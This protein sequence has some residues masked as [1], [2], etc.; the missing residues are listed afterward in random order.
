MNLIGK[1]VQHKY[2]GQIGK[3]IGISDGF[4]VVSFWDEIHRYKQEDAFE[5][6]EL[7]NKHEQSL[8]ENQAYVA[9]V[10]GFRSEEGAAS[11]DFF[12]RLRNGAAGT[13]ERVPADPVPECGGCGI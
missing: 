3:I 7:E 13:D 9:G 6:I 1:K 12:C 5:Y 8:L 4:V 10:P 11:A 2:A